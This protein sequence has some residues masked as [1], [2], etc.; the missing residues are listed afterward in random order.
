MAMDRR[1]GCLPELLAAII[2]YPQ[3]EISPHAISSVEKAIQTAPS[4]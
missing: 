1:H 4:T 3:L 2:A